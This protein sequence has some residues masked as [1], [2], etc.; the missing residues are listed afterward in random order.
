MIDLENEIAKAL[1]EYSQEVTDKIKNAVDIVSA[2]VD[3]EIKN[4]IPF[5]QR[6]GRYV[7]AFRIKNTYENQYAKTNVWHVADGQHRL[8]HLLE[9]GHA[10]LNGGRVKAYPHVQYGEDLAAKRMLE[11]AREAVQT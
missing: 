11:L 1:S 3:I 7:K 10:K 2:E 6:T 8:T 9:H 4:K 5:T